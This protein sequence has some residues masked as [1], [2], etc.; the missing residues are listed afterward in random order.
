MKLVIAGSSFLVPG[1]KA[2][3]GLDRQMSVNFADYGDW[4]G[5]LLR[6]APEE[7]VAVVLFLDD[8]TDVRRRDE[9]DLR[10]LLGG[11][12]GLLKRRLGEARSPT[13]VAFA[14]CDDATVVQKARRAST[15][16]LVHE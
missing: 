2:W 6:A 10:D 5:T 14:S 7:T 15:A 1:N 11:F 13:I 3:R 9:A 12:L 4:N 16:S 8:L